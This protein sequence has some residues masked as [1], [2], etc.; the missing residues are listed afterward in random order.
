MQNTSN[1]ISLLGFDNSLSESQLIQW[2]TSKLNRPPDPI[3]YYS[4]G[5]LLYQSGLFTAASR[6]LLLYINNS[7]FSIDQ[8]TA[9]GPGNHLLAYSYYMDGQ[10]NSA[11][12]HL[13]YSVNG[14]FDSDWQLLIELQLMVE[15]Q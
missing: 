11:I 1:S 4:T 8:S 15:S 14:G 9:I 13:K 10:Y 2:L 5:K 12:T 6:L 7:K 3:D